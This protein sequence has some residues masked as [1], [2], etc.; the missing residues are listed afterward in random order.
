MCRYNQRGKTQLIRSNL[1]FENFFQKCFIFSNQDFFI[2]SIQIFLN[3]WRH[4]VPIGGFSL[5]RLRL[6]TTVL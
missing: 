5:V 4:L 2:S 3:Q 1:M 6:I